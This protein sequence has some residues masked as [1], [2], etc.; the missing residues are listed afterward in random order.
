[1][2]SCLNRELRLDRARL[3]R[4]VVGVV[5][6]QSSQGVLKV[7]APNTRRMYLG[8]GGKASGSK[9]AR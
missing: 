6:L 1:M 9:T 7:C 3:S 4:G 8:E 5:L 2:S